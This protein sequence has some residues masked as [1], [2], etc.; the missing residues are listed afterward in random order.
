VKPSQLIGLPYRLGAEPDKHR[1]GDCLSITRTVIK[2]YG[3]NFPE[4]KREWYRRLW[5]KDK[6]VFKEELS[7][8]GFLTTTAKIGVVA[9]CSSKD[10]YA[11]A[12]YWEKG[13]ISFVNQEVKWSP[14]EGLG[15][16]E[17]YYPMKQ[18][19]AMS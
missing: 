17:L 5:K 1:A 11:L 8:W 9:L 3:I 15:V 7:K 18:N 12:V 10:G 19:F 4:T 14:L 16:Q 13:W 6:T 2:S